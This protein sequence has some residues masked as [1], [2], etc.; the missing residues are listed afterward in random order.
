MIHQ[1]SGRIAACFLKHDLI[2]RQLL[3]HLQYKI[4]ILLQSLPFVLCLTFLAV[5]TKRYG[6]LAIFTITVC[7]LRRRMGGWHA[8]SPGLCFVMSLGIV[9]LSVFVLGPLFLRMPTGMGALLCLLLDIFALHMTPAY[10]PQ[11][12]LDAA[13]RSANIRRTKRLLWI[14]LVAQSIAFFI[15]CPLIL[16]YTFLGLAITVMAVLLEKIKL[17]KGVKSHETAEIHH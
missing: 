15:P 6:E 9:I 11:M 8:P 1:L 13:E 7:L 16:A 5:L 17:N 3:P 4:E 14:L 10:P 2:D 12:H